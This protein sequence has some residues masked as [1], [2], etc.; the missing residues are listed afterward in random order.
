MYCPHCGKE[1]IEGAAFCVHCGKVVV[2]AATATPAA[3]ATETAQ[4]AQALQ[5]TVTFVRHDVE[6]PDLTITMSSGENASLVNKGSCSFSL[7]RGSQK[8]ELDAGS[9]HEEMEITLNGDITVNLFWLG[10]QHRFHIVVAEPLNPKTESA[11][12]AAAE[13]AA[14]ATEVWANALSGVNRTR[15][16][17]AGL[18]ELGAA[19]LMFFLPIVSVFSMFEGSV[20]LNTMEF[21]EAMNNFLAYGVSFNKTMWGMLIIV[22]LWLGIFFAAISGIAALVRPSKL[23]YSLYMGECGLVAFVLALIIL[24]AVGDSMG[25]SPSIGL[26]VAIALTTFAVAVG[27]GNFK[28]VRSELKKAKEQK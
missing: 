19:L 6:G 26:W 25:V 15:D 17:I 5:Y 13:S 1:V 28:L 9:Q 3:S 10:I 4:V 14:R 12:S 16:I 22:F 27:W 20:P 24:F 8:F 21:T 23:S 7:P 18:L 2:P 11:S